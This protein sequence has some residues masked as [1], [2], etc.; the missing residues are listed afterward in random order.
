M[1]LILTVRISRGYDRWCG[2]G[3]AL[4]RGAAVGG[5]HAAV[6]RPLPGPA[7]LPAALLPSCRWQARSSIGQA[8]GSLVGLMTQMT[9]Y[10]KDEALIV[11]GACCWGWQAACRSWRSPACSP[12]CSLHCR[13]RCRPRRLLAMRAA[14]PGVAATPPAARCPPP[15]SLAMQREALRWMSV[16]AYIVHRTVLRAPKVLPECEA[17]LSEKE[18]G[19]LCECG[20]CCRAGGS[21]RGAWRQ[22]CADAALHCRPTPRPPRPH[23]A[24]PQPASSRASW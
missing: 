12:A 5:R 19:L 24:A 14:R 13:Q 1:S 10:V 6:A 21:G 3:G 11:G 16:W 23:R 2:G 4:E 8:N 22:L 7:C 17:L 18:R 15:C 9:T 20:L